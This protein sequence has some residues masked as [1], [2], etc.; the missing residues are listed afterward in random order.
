MSHSTSSSG[1]DNSQPEDIFKSA[2]NLL[3]KVAIVTAVVV[4]ILVSLAVMVAPD[5]A[6]A[7][8][9]DMSEKAIAQ[10]IQKVG[11]LSFGATVAAGPRSGEDLYKGR[12]AGCHTAGVLGA[13]KLGDKAGWA[14]RI[15][16]GYETLVQSALKGKNAMPAQAGGDY[17]NEDVARAVTYLA[18]SAGANF[19][20]PG[21]K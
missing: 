15:A 21:A 17:S 19:K 18:N 4:G 16:L 7:G 6:P 3:V 8:R 13:P 9:S 5:E 10:R 11:T 2:A 14:A 20:E 1:Q 12:C